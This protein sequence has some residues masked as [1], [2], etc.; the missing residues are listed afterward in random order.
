MRERRWVLLVLVVLALTAGFLY[1]GWRIS[2]ASQRIYNLVMD[3][4][5]PALGQGFTLGSVEVGFGTLHLRDVRLQRAAYSVQ[6]DDVRLGFSLVRLLLKGKESAQL[7]GDALL[8]NP[9]V[10]FLRQRLPLN[11]SEDRVGTSQGPAPLSGGSGPF[12]LLRRVTVTGGELVLVDTAAS[13]VTLVREVEGVLA[14]EGRSQASL[15]LTGKPFTS[16][17]GSVELRGLIDLDGLRLRQGEL[18]LRGWDLSKLPLSDH[19]I[20]LT[21][22]KLQ[23]SCSVWPDSATG[24]A[25]RLA[26]DLQLTDAKV[27]LGERT[28]VMEEGTVQLRGSTEELVV[29][30][31]GR[32]PNQAELSLNGTVAELVHPRV[33]LTL[34]GRN[35]DL[36]ELAPFAF[37]GGK[38]RLR[39]FFTGEVAVRGGLDSLRGEGWVASPRMWFDKMEVRQA[40]AEFAYSDS[41]VR[42]RALRASAV[43]NAWQGSGSLTLTRNGPTIRA[44]LKAKGDV[45]QELRR[46]LGVHISS[47]RDSATAEMG[48]TLTAPWVQAGFALTLGDSGARAVQ[49]RGNLSYA[50]GR[51]EVDAVGDDDLH[52][53]GWTQARQVFAEGRNLHVLVASLWPKLVPETVRRHVEFDMALQG[54]PDSLQTRMEGRWRDANDLVHPLVLLTGELQ[55]LREQRTWRNALRLFPDRVD[56]TPGQL[57]VVFRKR[58]VEISKLTLGSSVGAWLKLDRGKL[59]GD[60]RVR[61][62]RIEKLTFVPDSLVRGEL[63]G[64]VAFAGSLQ[65]PQVKGAVAFSDAYFHGEGPFAGALS[66]RTEGSAL[67][68]EELAVKDGEREVVRGEFSLDASGRV[69]RL[70]VSGQGIDLN[71]AFAAFSGLRDV[72]RGEANLQV[73]AEG[74]SDGLDVSAEVQVLKGKVF[75]VG[76]DTLHLSVAGRPDSVPDQ[77]RGAQYARLRTLRLV[78]NDGFS[79]Q[80]QGALPLDLEEPLAVEAEG[81]G[82]LLRLL[83]S[84][85][86]FV[87]EGKS[88]C[89]VRL[90]LG[91][92]WSSPRLE[93]GELT[94]E[95]GELRCASIVPVI[96]QLKGTMRLR[97]ESHFVE[98]VE[99]RGLMGGEPFVIYNVPSVGKGYRRSLLPFE[100]EELG[101]SLGIL[102]IETSPDGIVLNIPGLM[103]QGEYGRFQL[104]GYGAEDRFCV[105]GPPER[106][107]VYGTMV[108]HGVEFAYPFNESGGVSSHLTQVLEGVDWD[109]RVV[110]GTNT[111]YV[112][113]LPGAL[114]NVYVT[115][116]LDE[117]Y[118]GLHF[119]GRVSDETFRV[120]GEL[121][122]TRG[123]VEYLDMNF[124][125][126]QAGIEF[127]RNT[128]IPIVYGRAYT[129]VADSNGIPCQ[130]YLTLATVDRALEGRKVDERVLDQRYRARWDELRFQLSS[131]NASLGS[132]EAQLLASLGYTP[133]RLRQKTVDVI[134]ISADNLVF[135]HLFRPF[136]RRLEN[137]LGLDVVRL[138]SRLTRNFIEMNLASSVPIP[139]KLYLLRSTRLTVGKYLSDDLYLVYTGQLESGLDYRY[140]VPGLG[141]H[142]TFGLELRLN[143][144]LLIEMEYDYDGLMLWRKDDTRFWIRHWF[145][146]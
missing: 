38:S 110:P 66:F 71:R 89:A 76:I 31:R 58:G 69:S 90:R 104:L 94:L 96:K 122:S 65:A 56:E 39:G 109:L 7:G 121:K 49:V 127:D 88:R 129:T 62:A 81:K 78:R 47:C 102:V 11:Q 17:G 108:L 22:G 143:P 34:A 131:D 42:I 137:Y 48:G 135:R 45:A 14:A 132:T 3:T 100:L 63:N 140:Q 144:K 13:P 74:A 123:S 119:T 37:G 72:V 92:T 61:G 84:S 77:A 91:G 32:L 142:H 15:H 53:R 67:R 130:I 117:R 75:G 51:L 105:A 33:Q 19:G 118:G 103:E 46:L 25:L 136:E 1:Y 146:F 98:L 20:P 59:Q 36:A 106:P 55:G 138:S 54:T 6:I 10:S 82:D 43:G 18:A 64:E 16:R 57:E 30:A 21:D 40:K 134:G 120:E 68:V 41:V 5:R 86:G 125:L 128:L 26:C 28:L 133:D 115:L 126:E 116:D 80:A 2:G 12:T 4:A 139:S 73:K 50:T 107:V 114:D 23:G 29:E 83:A 35:L 8:I 141:L 95:D 101:V 112:K 124:R 87:K 93:E 52:V 113:K 85:G 60:V 111:R 79:V 44:S 24:S 99:L 27:T 9:R 97:P 145:P 70:S